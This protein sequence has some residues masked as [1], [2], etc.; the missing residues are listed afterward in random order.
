MTVEPRPSFA[1]LR[2]FLAAG[3][4][5]SFRAAAA[6]LR[7][8]PAAVSQHVQAVEAWA[9]RP[10]FDRGVRQVRL[11]A[12]GSRFLDQLEIGFRAIDA[13]LA[14]VRT[15]ADGSALKIT[16]LPL[17]TQAWLV[18]RLGRFE[19]Q[20]PDIRLEIDTESRVLRV[21]EGEADVGIRNAR[22]DGSALA[23][24]KLLDLRAVPL[25]APDLA[26]RLASPADLRNVP[27]IH[28]AGRRQGWAAWLRRVGED[29]LRP[30]TARVFDSLPTALEAAARGQGVLLGVDPLV[31]DMPQ[32]EHLVV[33]FPTPP[34]SAGSYRLVHRKAD[35]ARRDIAA[36]I[37]WVRAEMKADLPRLRRLSATRG[38]RPG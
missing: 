3:R 22:V 4:R 36:F 13:A 16:S 37:D 26:R 32:A 5:Q 9:G 34:V 30:A 7:V 17:F 10:L 15:N 27:L 31:W 33:P 1:A 23:A 12:E 19:R 14:D 25:C 6:D 2:T 21:E 38:G 29:D 8:T 35:R 11:T 28:I 24:F 18:P 20:Y